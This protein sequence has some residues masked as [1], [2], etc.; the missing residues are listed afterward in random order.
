[1]IPASYAVTIFATF[2]RVEN[3]VDVTS[4][5]N[6]HFMATLAHSEIVEALTC[7]G[8]LALERHTEVELLLVGGALMVLR[9]E[10]RDATRDEVISVA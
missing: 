10:S 2:K 3:S 7:V 4:Q 1:M 8:A 9:F 5:G 6:I